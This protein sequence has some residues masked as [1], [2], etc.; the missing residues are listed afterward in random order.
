MQ[1]KLRVCCDLDDTI[2][3]FIPAILQRYN[4]KYNDDLSIRCITDYEIRK[5]LKPECEHLFQEFANKKL[6]KKIVMSQEVINTLTEMN[7]KYE[8]YFLT[9]GHPKT[10]RYRDK[11]LSR[12]LPWYSSGQLISCR[13][14]WLVKFDVLVDDCVANINNIDG[15]GILIKQPWNTLSGYSKALTCEKFDKTVIETI[16]KNI[17]RKVNN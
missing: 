2:Y 11:L 12:Y 15:V 16:E 9:A 4:K 3:G 1:K 14:K 13:N 7:E 5:F 6:F 17:N 8:L 10:T